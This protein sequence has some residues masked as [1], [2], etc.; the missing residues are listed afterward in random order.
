MDEVYV[1]QIATTGHKGAPKD[2]VTEIAVC[3]MDADGSDFDTIMA[4]GIM[5]DPLDLGKEPLDFMLE[6]YGISPNDLYTGIDEPR[7]VEDFQRLVYGKECT[8]FNVGNVFGKYLSFE[9]W[10]G[11][12]E[13]TLLPSI[14][15]RL[16]SEFKGSPEQEHVL[17]RRTYE[18]LC[19]GDPAQVDDGKRALHLAQMSTCILM[20]LRREGMF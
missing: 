6:N 5:I 16:P 20:K 15:M 18:A 9:P 10:D 12:R 14:S 11:A 2:R 8:S 13:I 3:R 4:E 19:P 7:V 1:V 17:I